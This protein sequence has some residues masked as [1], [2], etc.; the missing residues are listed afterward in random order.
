[1]CAFFKKYMHRRGLADAP[2]DRLHQLARE[3]LPWK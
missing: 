2:A 3:E 1:M